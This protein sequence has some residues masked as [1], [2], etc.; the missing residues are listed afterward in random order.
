[1]IIG[2]S[3]AILIGLSL[4]LMGGGGSILTV[5]VLVYILDYSPKDSIALSLAIVGTTTLFGSLSHFK[6]RNIDLKA[7]LAFAPTAMI[8]SFFGAKVSVLLSGQLQ[9]VIFSIVMLIAAYFMLKG[10]KET[11]VP[12]DNANSINYPSIVFA[13]LF[14][15]FLTGIIGVG[16]GFMIVPA[17]VLL[18]NIPMKKA[19]GSSLVIITLNSFTGFLGHIESANIEWDFLIQFSIFTTIGIFIGS[20]FVK[21]ISQN[22]L[23]KS[24]AIFLVIMGFVILYKNY[25]V[26][27]N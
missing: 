4:G 7:S 3:L 26:I 8:G 15:G 17:L 20:Y 23:K 1:M 19:I 12:E 22:M 11:P 21:F 2:L 13:G 6:N 27:S 16:G 5:P 24:F 14:V 25:S 9:L 10:R 18:A